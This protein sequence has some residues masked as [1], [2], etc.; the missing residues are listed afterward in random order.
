MAGHRG[1]QSRFKPAPFNVQHFTGRGYAVVDDKGTL[2]TAIYRD[3]GAVVLACDAKN[4]AAQQKAKA[5]PRPCL[6]CGAQFQS[7]GIHNRMCGH[8]RH[9]SSAEGE[10]VG[11]SFG[12]MTGRRR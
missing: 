4:T 10:P 12:A 3:R 8:C 7:A 5:I 1:N 6:R 2:V 11:Y 9:A